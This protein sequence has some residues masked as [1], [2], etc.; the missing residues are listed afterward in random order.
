MQRSI[1]ASTSSCVNPSASSRLTTAWTTSMHSSIRFWRYSLRA[2][3]IGL[4]R[5]SSQSCQAPYTSAAS[6]SGLS[7]CTLGVS[8]SSS[9]P[10]SNL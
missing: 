4:R 9:A 1:A 5:M 2:V 8:G 7:A 10:N 3:M 6:S